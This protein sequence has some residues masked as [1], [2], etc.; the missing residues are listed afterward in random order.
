MRRD[1][2]GPDEDDDFLEEAEQEQEDGPN[3]DGIVRDRQAT[4]EREV[5]RRAEEAVADLPD[6]DE[7]T[8]DER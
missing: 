2:H 3:E 6:R 7:P 5:L 8:E 4:E 1:D